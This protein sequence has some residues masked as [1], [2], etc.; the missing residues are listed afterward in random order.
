MEFHIDN[1]RTTTSNLSE[2]NLDSLPSVE[3]PPPAVRNNGSAVRTVIAPDPGYDGI[4]YTKCRCGKWFHTGSFQRHDCTPI[5]GG[6]AR[7]RRTLPLTAHD[8]NMKEKPWKS[9]W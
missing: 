9:G 6:R 3:P 4:A 1:P 2:N 7:R 5:A 8:N